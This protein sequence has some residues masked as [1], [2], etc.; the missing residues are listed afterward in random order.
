MP[1]VTHRLR[2]RGLPSPWWLL[3]DATNLLP[4]ERRAHA[5]GYARGYAAGIALGRRQRDAEL[6]DQESRD[7]FLARRIVALLLQHDYQGQL[8]QAV[9]A[10]PIS[11]RK[12]LQPDTEDNPTRHDLWPAPDPS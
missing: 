12:R 9:G 8:V 1:R 5:A 10:K 3:V 4:S 7:E 2:E 6:A 11:W